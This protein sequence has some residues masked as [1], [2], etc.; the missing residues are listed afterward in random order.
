MVNASVR[1]AY[2]NPIMI[3]AIIL[4]LKKIPFDLLSLLPSFAQTFQV[5]T[6]FVFFVVLPLAF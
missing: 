1:S 5:A 4:L 2:F 6:H 3:H